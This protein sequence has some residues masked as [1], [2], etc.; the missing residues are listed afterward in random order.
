M[1]GGVRGGDLSGG[2]L[3]LVSA[4]LLSTKKL[5]DTAGHGRK[6]RHCLSWVELGCEIISI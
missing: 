3:A 6:Y 5:K 2:E 4:K 1:S